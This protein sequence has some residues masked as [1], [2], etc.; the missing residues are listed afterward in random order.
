MIIR[1]EE[2]NDYC[3]V[4][5]LI[6][7]AF[8]TTEYTDGN[9]QNLAAALRKGTAF[10]PELSLVAEMNGEL[11]GHIMFTTAVVGGDEIL[12]LAPLSVKPRYQHQ[13]VGTA[14]IKEGHKIARQLGYEYSLVL[15][16]ETYYPRTGYRPAVQF[17]IEVP[18]GF[19]PENF[20]AVKLQEAAKPISGVVIYAKEFG[21]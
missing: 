3:E 5:E 15:G 8:S 7:E 19:P 9:E 16:S 1:Q 18:E 2:P 13:G 10:I 12:A 14:L 11:V 4:Y 20:M 6:K 17:G 21:L